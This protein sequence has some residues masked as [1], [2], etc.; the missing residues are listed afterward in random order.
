MRTYKQLRC[1]DAEETEE[2]CRGVRVFAVGFAPSAGQQTELSGAGRAAKASLPLNRD[3][4][5]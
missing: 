2:P 5:E 1:E 4:V 3:V